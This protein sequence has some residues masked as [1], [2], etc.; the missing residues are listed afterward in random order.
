M[1]TQPYEA[2]APSALPASAAYVQRLVSEH[3]LPVAV[4]LSG[5]RTRLTAKELAANPAIDHAALFL[6]DPHVAN[7]SAFCQWPELPRVVAGGVGFTAPQR[8]TIYPCCEGTDALPSYCAAFAPD[9]YHD[10]ARFPAGEWLLDLRNASAHSIDAVT[11]LI[12]ATPEDRIAELRAEVAAAGLPGH[13]VAKLIEFLDKALTKLASGNANAA[14]G[15][16]KGFVNKVRDLVA[17]GRLTPEQGTTLV[18]PAEALI[19]QLA[20]GA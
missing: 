15:R 10:Y 19:A 7:W 3:G 13:D 18:E 14:M 2:A 17:V 6:R 20:A 4:R 1:D 5:D 11:I 16:L 8:S 9:G 12:P